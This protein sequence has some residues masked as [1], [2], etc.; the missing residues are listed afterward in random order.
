MIPAVL[1]ESEHM[2]T[3]AQEI[4]RSGGLVAQE[5]PGPAGHLN[6]QMLDGSCPR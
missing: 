5:S 4:A 6:R 2:V 3:V 1:G